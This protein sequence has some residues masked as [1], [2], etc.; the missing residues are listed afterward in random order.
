MPEAAAALCVYARNNVLHLFALPALLGCLLS[1]ERA[2]PQ[3]EIT[4][5]CARLY[6]YLSAV[7]CLAWDEAEL[8]RVV[9]GTLAAMAL[10]GLV[11]AEPPSGSWCR[12]PRAAAGVDGLDTLCQ[13]IVPMLQSIYCVVASF[14]EAGPVGLTADETQARCASRAAE[15]PTRPVADP[16]L[17]R[18]LIDE[19]SA[20]DVLVS[21][22][23]ARLKSAG[24]DSQLLIDLTSVLACATPGGSWSRS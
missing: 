4:A 22:Q 16:A 14:A 24:R 17:I 12:M 23:D 15:D 2:R 9:S 10:V 18:T 5:L 6:P 19:L 8:A 3:E 1:D 7:L 21:G 20:R 11:K 13:A